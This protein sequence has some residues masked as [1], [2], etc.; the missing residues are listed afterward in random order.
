MSMILSSILMHGVTD[1]LGAVSYNMAKF[2][3]RKLSI[4]RLCTLKNK[5]I[6][7]TSF[8]MTVVALLHISI[9]R[10][11]WWCSSGNGA[12]TQEILRCTNVCKNTGILFVP[13]H[14]ISDVT[15]IRR[16]RGKI[17]RRINRFTCSPRHMG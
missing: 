12:T 13:S 7:V 11:E 2:L 10:W 1:V 3:L 15:D 17:K 8:L 5:S 9:P 6:R 4:I 14:S 16:D